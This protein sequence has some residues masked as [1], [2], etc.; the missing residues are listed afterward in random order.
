MS[1]HSNKGNCVRDILKKILDAQAEVA[2]ADE[3]DVSCERSIRDLVGPATGGNGDTTIPF[4]LYCE[5]CKPF[6]ASGVKKINDT[7]YCVETPIFKAIKFTD[8]K[9]NCIKLELLKPDNNSMTLNSRCSKRDVCDLVNGV[10]E[11]KST[12]ICMTFDLNCICGITCLDTTTPVPV[13]EADFAPMHV[14]EG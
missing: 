10:T 7:F 6:F 12:G 8:D 5:D 1:Y 4:I 9:K 2:M 3:C 13:T 14:C 11:F